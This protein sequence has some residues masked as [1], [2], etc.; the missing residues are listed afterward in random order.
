MSPIE[1]SAPPVSPGREITHAEYLDTRFFANL[2]G[3]RALAVL[4]VI[5]FHGDRFGSAAM[6]RV[7]EAGTSGV[8]VFFVLSGF[9]ITTLLLRE[10]PRPMGSTLRG[11]YVRRALRIFPLYYAAIPLYAVAAWTSRVPGDAQEFVRYLPSL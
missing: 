11:F 6:E 8:D 4:A 5:L 1:V 7:R 3:V 2:D 10:K 9:L